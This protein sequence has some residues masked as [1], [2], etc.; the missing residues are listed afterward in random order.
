MFLLPRFVSAYG[1]LID[2][3][4]RKI[5]LNGQYEKEICRQRP[6]TCACF[7]GTMLYPIYHCR[8][9]PGVI[10]VSRSWDGELIDK[11]LRRWGF[12]TVRG[13][14]SRRGKEALTE[15]IDLV[16]QENFNAG[17]AVDAP[18][19]PAEKVKIGVVL[20]SRETGNPVVPL[21]SWATRK[22]RF[23]SWDKMMLPLPFSTIVLVFGKPFFIPPDLERN[24]YE[25]LREEIEQEMKRCQVKAKEEAEALLAR[26]GSFGWRQAREKQDDHC[27]V[28]RHL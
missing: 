28:P 17:L 12:R 19:G 1:W 10:M 16:K 3:T 4:C 18:R 26:G 27:T 9:Y 21:V 5:I 15:M 23:N 24:D 6:F 8:R 2:L 13:S 22:V 20:L 7:H 25:R 11:C 14:S